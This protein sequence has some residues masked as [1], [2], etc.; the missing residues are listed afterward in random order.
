MTRMDSDESFAIVQKDIIAGLGEVFAAD[1]DGDDSDAVRVADRFR[2]E[3][4]ITNEAVAAVPWVYRCRHTGDFNG[5]FRTGRSL[6]IKGV[7]F[8]D[9]RGGQLLL[10]RYV[11]WEG[12]IAQL[13][14]SVSWRVPVTEDE[15]K[16]G[17]EPVTPP[18]S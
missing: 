11:D 7:T 8:V 3:E 1:N 5:L 10:H 2:D 12:V 6:E 14:L 18:E 9:R 13:G 4:V 16:A 15:Y 17:R